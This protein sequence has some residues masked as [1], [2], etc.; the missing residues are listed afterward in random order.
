MRPCAVPGRSADREGRG[1]LSPS[2]AG[3]GTVVSENRA[4]VLRSAE[5]SDAHQGTLVS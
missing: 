2:D 4:G 3:S 1:R 5:Y